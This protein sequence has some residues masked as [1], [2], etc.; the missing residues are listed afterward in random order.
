MYFFGGDRAVL[1]NT[2][3]F[4][5]LTRQVTGRRLPP[6]AAVRRAF[7]VA[8]LWERGKSLPHSQSTFDCP[9]PEKY[10]SVEDVATLWTR[11]I[12][13]GSRS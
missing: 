9:P 2:V 10:D 11:L 8:N 12:I 5:T 13:E 6:A 7:S 3:L 1:Y 4:L